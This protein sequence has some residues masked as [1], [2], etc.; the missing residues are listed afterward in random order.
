MSNK[1]KPSKNSKHEQELI[2]H[3]KLINEAF[4]KSKPSTD[5]F[6]VVIGSYR[7]MVKANG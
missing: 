3:S 6:D 7:G 4:D 1:T 5:W 2:N